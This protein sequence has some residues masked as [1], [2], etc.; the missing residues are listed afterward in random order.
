VRAMV[1]VMVL[2]V[3]ELLTEQLDVDSAP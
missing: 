1:I 2:P 3:A